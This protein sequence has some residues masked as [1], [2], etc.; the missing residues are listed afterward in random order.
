MADSK[1]EI[2]VGAFSFS[3]EGTGDWLG[4]QLDKVL[5]KMPELIGLSEAEDQEDKTDTNKPATATK[6]AAHGKN[7]TTLAAFI[8]EKKATSNQVRKF[9]ATAAWLHDTTDQKRLAT[10][11]V[12][13]ALSDHN[14]GKLTNP[15]QSLNNNAKTGGIVKEGKKFYVSDEGRAE[16]DK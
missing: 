5:A 9:L 12:T 15:S 13:K 6:S 3:G 10:G 4:K 16:L 11:D 14:Q 7:A 8:K 2:K 1:I